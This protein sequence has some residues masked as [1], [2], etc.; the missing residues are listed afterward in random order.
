M[1]SK[2]PGAAQ[3]PNTDPT[4]IETAST[5]W[6]W[7]RDGLRIGSGDELPLIYWDTPTTRISVH[8]SLTNSDI[9][10]AM[11]SIPRFRRLLVFGIVL[12]NCRRSSHNNAEPTASFAISLA[13]HQ[14]CLCL[15]VFLAVLS[16][17][18][19]TTLHRASLGPLP[20]SSRGLPL[21]FLASPGP[22]GS[23]NT[24]AEFH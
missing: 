20:G 11:P 19:R 17:K 1:V 22:P 4:K 15:L 14:S 12:D 8:P 18:L 21:F 7:S 24:A 13:R 10:S 16:A 2:S 6:T 5:P 9:T 23:K 3:T